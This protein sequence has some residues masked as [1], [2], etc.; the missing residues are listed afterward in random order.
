MVVCPEFS[1]MPMR[2]GS[3]VMRLASKV[4]AYL[5]LTA[6]A[7]LMDKIGRVGMCTHRCTSNIKH[8]TFHSIRDQRTHQRNNISWERVVRL[9]DLGNRLIVVPSLSTHQEGCYS[10]IIQLQLQPQLQLQQSA[11]LN[12]SSVRCLQLSYLSEQ[13]GRGWQAG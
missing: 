7:D 13:A 11:N 2:C 10:A 5:L 3:G 8:Q 12:S 4:L 1:H 9:Y 6:V